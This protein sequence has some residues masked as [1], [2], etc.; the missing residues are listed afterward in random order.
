MENRNSNLERVWSGM[1]W[2]LLFIVIGLIFFA[3]NL[4]WMPGENGWSYF[5][6]GLGGILIIGFLVR[7]YGV[8][9]KFLNGLVS[10]ATGLSLVFIGISSICGFLSLWPLALIVIGAGYLIKSF[11]GA[12][13]GTGKNTA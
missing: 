11:W 5:A 9:T 13:A 1:G 6:I 8:H 2:G 7:F 3:G 12:R 4:G 10:L